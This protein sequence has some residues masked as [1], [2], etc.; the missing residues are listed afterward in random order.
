MTRFESESYV[1]TDGQSVSPIWNK[2]SI[3]GL[4]PDFYYCQTVADLLMWG[5]LSDERTAL[6]FTITAGTRRRNRSRV[7][8][9]WD[10]RPILLPQIRDFLFCR[11]LRLAGLQWRYSTP[12]PHGRLTRLPTVF[13]IT[14]LHGPSRKRRFQQ[15]LYC[16]KVYPLPRERVYRA[17]AY[18]RMLFQSHYL[19]TAGSDSPVLT[20]RKYATLFYVI[21]KT[22][23]W[24]GWVFKTQ[25][26]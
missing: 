2:A 26:S 17:V 15:H 20:L 13:R 25:S 11:L 18:N 8:V 23:W 12:P 16:C 6:S 1:M 7:R 14:S 10:S 9:P 3:W 19:A 24:I 22:V 5:A 21:L 4:R